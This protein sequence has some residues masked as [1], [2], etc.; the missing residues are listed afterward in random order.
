MEDNKKEQKSAVFSIV[1]LDENGEE[2]SSMTPIEKTH[3]AVVSINIG[4]L[5][6]NRE[7]GTCL[8]KGFMQERTEEFERLI[9][10]VRRN[11]AQQS[12]KIIVPNSGQ[13]PPLSVVH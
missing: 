12:K 11:R 8:L 1:Y 5:I 6:P 10:A 4:A 3:V 2:I 9:L 7:M 13:V